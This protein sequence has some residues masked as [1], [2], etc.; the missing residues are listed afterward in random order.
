MNT[1]TATLFIETN[2]LSREKLAC[3]LLAITPQK[4]FFEWAEAKVKMAEGLAEKEYKGYFQQRLRTIERALKDEDRER[5]QTTNGLFQ[6]LLSQSHFE[7]LEQYNAGPVQFG[8][9]KPYGE[10][11]DAR[12]FARLFKD[13][14]HQPVVKRKRSGSGLYWAVLNKLDRPAIVS[15]ADVQYELPEESID[16]LIYNAKLSMI[17]V[18]GSI[19]AMQAVDMNK[20]LNTVVQHLNET[21]MIYH[22]LV[23]LGKQKSTP[24]ERVKLVYQPEGEESDLVKKVRTE[25]SDVFE[26]MPLGELDQKLE[27]MENDPS[28]RRFSE[29]IEA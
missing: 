21:E 23:K 13:T 17:T 14:V 9:I 26:L 7:R 10:H 25:K 19:Q 16:G 3:G 4:L 27:R 8:D 11:I 1:F 5:Q 18:N 24:V 28:Y 6:G 15:K 22:Q 20:S 29:F 2:P 12:L